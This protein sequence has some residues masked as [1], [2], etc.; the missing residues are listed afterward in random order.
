MMEIPLFLL[1]DDMLSALLVNYLPVE[2]IPAQVNDRLQRR[3]L[4]TVRGLQ[5]TSKSTERALFAREDASRN[6]AKSRLQ[7]GCSGEEA[8]LHA[9]VAQKV[10]IKTKLTP[11]VE[12][13]RY[14]QSGL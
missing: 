13:Q 2:P 3:V 9:S 14:Q 5:S 10:R 7:N 6:W 12:T 4:E 1:S 8:A 11:S